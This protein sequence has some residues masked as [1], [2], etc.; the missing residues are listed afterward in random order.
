[1]QIPQNEDTKVKDYTEKQEATMEKSCHM[2]YSWMIR[3]KK[4]PITS[5]TPNFPRIKLH[6][7]T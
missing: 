1:M 4:V 2:F 3:D 5:L 6:N 7:F